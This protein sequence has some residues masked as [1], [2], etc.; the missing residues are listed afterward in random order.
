MR[1]VLRDVKTWRVSDMSKFAHIFLKWGNTPDRWDLRTTEKS[2]AVGS[3]GGVRELQFGQDGLKVSKDHIWVRVLLSQHRLFQPAVRP[4]ARSVTGKD[5]RSV[6]GMCRNIRNFC[7]LA[8]QESLFLDRP[9][10]RRYGPIRLIRSVSQP[11]KSIELVGWPG[12]GESLG[13][14]GFSNVLLSTLC[15]ASTTLSEMKLSQRAQ[16]VT[17]SAS[18]ISAGKHY[19]ENDAS[20]C[21]N[22]D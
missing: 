20:N 5:V 21:R 2:S 11:T 7:L 3:P 10:V 13:S 22:S 17:L 14:E 9:A 8:F 6:S 18:P 15:G 1:H 4:D 16:R 12:V 19:A